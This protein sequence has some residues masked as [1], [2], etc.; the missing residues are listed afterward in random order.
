MFEQLPN[1]HKHLAR[2]IARL[3]DAFES[4]FRLLEIGWGLGQPSER[5]ISVRDDRS[6]R[7]ADFMGDR[8]R[9]FAHGRQPRHLRELRLRR[10]HGFV[11]ADAFASRR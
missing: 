6:E 2:V 7:L 4:R 1:A 9:E 3:D 10:V 8:R 11:G 5:P